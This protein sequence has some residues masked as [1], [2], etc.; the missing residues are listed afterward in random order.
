MANVSTIWNLSVIH[1]NHVYQFCELFGAEDRAALFRIKIGV[2]DRIE[3]PWQPVGL[4]D[5]DWRFESSRLFSF[6]G[7][8]HC[9]LHPASLTGFAH[10][11]S[12]DQSQQWQLVTCM[13]VKLYSF[14]ICVVDSILYVIGGRNAPDEESPMLSTVHTCDLSTEKP[15]WDSVPVPDLPYGCTYPGVVILGSHVHVLSYLADETENEKKVISM[16]MRE[17]VRDRHWS[18]DTLPSTPNKRCMPVVMNDYLVLLGGYDDTGDVCPSV[19]LYVPECHQYLELPCYNM[20]G[21][22][23]CPSCLV[24]NNKLYIPNAAAGKIEYLSN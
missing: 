16:D 20:A 3:G 11:F 22:N 12:C 10:I 6:S 2:V 19:Y 15:E 1:H 9:I 8:M 5:G 7:R 18:C 14:G 24:Y 17:P 13:P 4:P 23:P 21:W